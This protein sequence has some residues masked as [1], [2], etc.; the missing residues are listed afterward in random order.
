MDLTRLHLLC[1][2]AMV[3]LCLTLSE[4]NIDDQIGAILKQL[5]D[6]STEHFKLETTLNQ[7]LT[8]VRS[9]K[10]TEALEN[11]NIRLA[12]LEKKLTGQQNENKR[13]DGELADVNDQLAVIK[14]EQRRQIGRDQIGGSTYIRWGRKDCPQNGT[15]KIYNGQAAGG[16]YTHSGTSPRMLCLPSEPVWGNYDD[17]QNSWGNFIYG[18]EYNDEGSRFQAIFGQNVYDLEVPCAACQS[19]RGSLVMIPGRTTCYDGWAMEYTGYLM[20]GHYSHAAQGDYNCVD[21]DPETLDGGKG[22]EN[23]YLLY[24]V[25]V[26]CESLRCPPYVMGRELPCV[27]CTK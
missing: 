19:S 9:F 16:H 26:R 12:D 7:V 15:M 13:L 6:K 1:L 8:E 21:A 5:Q 4:P 10:S 3:T 2:A 14:K 11:M 23:G 18:V 25:E 17:K 20:A 24:F 27:V 22:N